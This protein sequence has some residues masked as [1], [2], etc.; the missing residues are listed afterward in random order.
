M[1]GREMSDSTAQS[2]GSV[3]RPHRCP[4]IVQYMLVS[5]LRKL[6]EPAEKLLG[7]SVKVGMTVVEPGCGFGY[8]SLALAR[9]VG[10]EGKVISVDVEP[11]AVARLKKRA[12]RAGLADRIDAR[13]CEPRDL[14]LAEFAG[15]VDLV[16][17]IHTLHEFEDLPGFLAQVAVLL[18][19]TGRLWIVEPPGHVKPDHFA[20][21]KRACEAAGFRELT[22]NIAMGKK[23]VTLFA[24][25]AHSG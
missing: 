20:A 7:D 8:V 4:W 1:S 11:R 25:P 3:P 23:L 16:T 21:E 6:M 18:K 12:A 19:P 14:K 9:Q 10:P 24:P 17:M 13:A 15:Q 5:P 2:N 22:T